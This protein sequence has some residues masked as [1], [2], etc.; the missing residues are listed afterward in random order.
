MKVFVL[1]VFI[2]IILTSEVSFC[3]V[4]I[5][6]NP[7]TQIANFS[8]DFIEYEVE[9][10]FQELLVASARREVLTETEI[11]TNLNDYNVEM[12]INS[13]L[14]YYMPTHPQFGNSMLQPNP[15]DPHYLNDSN[16]LNRNHEIYLDAQERQSPY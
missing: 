16:G 3:Q 10:S 7:G 14:P 15:N 12:K 6:T 8:F 13:N 1:P 2:W 9:A 5:Y 4:D 11:S